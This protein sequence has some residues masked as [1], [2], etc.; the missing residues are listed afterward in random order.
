VRKGLLGRFVN[1]LDAGEET[2]DC[3]K[4]DAAVA[5]ILEQSDWHQEQSGDR[6]AKRWESAVTSAVMRVVETPG[7][8]ALCN[9]K[10]AQ[11][12]D[13]RRVSLVGFPKHLLFYEFKEKEM[14]VSPRP[15]WRSR[16]GKPVV[17]Q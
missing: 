15:P 11:L 6:L 8:G 16:P 10:P 14:L 5:D 12:H 7:A 9:F 1:G 4:S 17:K 13:V 3:P 2:S